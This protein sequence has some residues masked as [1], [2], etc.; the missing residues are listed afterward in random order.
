MCDCGCLFV[1][2]VVDVCVFLLWSL[3]LWWWL[4]SFIL[5][6]LL[7]CACNRGSRLVVCCYVCLL[8]FVWACCC[9][10]VIVVVVV[11]VFGIVGCVRCLL[12]FV[13]CGARLLLLVV[14][15]FVCWLLL[16]CR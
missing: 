1:F 4:N 11:G 5:R 10:F 3:C 16:V 12:V 2:V 14:L 15:P 13:V 7:R 6:I 9:S 8:L